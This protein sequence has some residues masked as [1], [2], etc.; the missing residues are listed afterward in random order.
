MPR[1]IVNPDKYSLIRHFLSSVW[2][3]PV[4][5]LL[6]L[7]IFTILGISGSSIGFYNKILYGENQKDTSLIANEPLAIRSDEWVV[8]TQMTIAQ[9]KNGL[10]QTN[11]NIGNGEDM[12][13][14]I[15]A[16]Y[17][18]WSA[19]FKPQNLSFF[20]LP[21]DNALAFKWWVMAYLLIVACYLFV[22]KLLPQQRILS[23]FISLGF[24]FSPFIQWWYQYSTLGTLAYCLFGAVIFIKILEEKNKIKCGLLGLLLAYVVACFVLVLYP[25]FQIPCALVMLAFSIGYAI[26]RFGTMPRRNLVKKLILILLSMLLAGCVGLAFLTTRPDTVQAIQNTVYPGKRVV[27]NGGYDI[28]HLFSG[29]LDS[30]LQSNKKSANYSIPSNNITNQSEISNFLFIWPFLLIVSILL[31]IVDYFRSRRIDEWAL[32]LVNALLV[33]FLLRIF[34]PTFD[35]LGKA[36]LLESV[37]HNRLM[38]GFGLLGLIQMTLFIRYLGNRKEKLSNMLVLLF[39]S[40][41]LLFGALVNLYTAHRFP[42]YIGNFKALAIAL[43]VAIIIYCI[44]GLRFLVATFILLLFSVYMTHGVNPL[45]KGTGVL[46]SNKIIRS[47][48]VAASKSPEEKWVI[49]NGYLENFAIMAGAKSLSGVYVY[50]QKDLWRLVDPT[51]QSESIYNRYAHVSINLDRNPERIVD[52]EFISPAL[53]HFGV[54]T[55]PCSKYLKDVGVGFALTD[56]PLDSSSKCLKLLNTVHYPTSNFYIYKIN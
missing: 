30:Q 36:I 49:E 20:L 12:S 11:V 18:D 29:G 53:D 45:Y 2:L 43:L 22:L 55:E 32:L 51:G 52:T 1:H 33:L 7:I 48:E 35:L 31:I 19:V 27:N 23:A 14:V 39:T 10:K 15:D 16:P 46:S 47:I 3:F 5:L 6:P 40:G 17:S 50:P 25:P 26:E 42:G 38:I 41:A 34:L 54:K 4:V 13:V 44:L 21:L 9:V 28:V 56:L 37:P 24:F 8:N